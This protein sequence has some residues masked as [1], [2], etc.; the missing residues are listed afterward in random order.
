MRKKRGEKRGHTTDPRTSLGA[1]HSRV[2]RRRSCA[3]AAARII[4]STVPA[5]RPLHRCIMWLCA[6]SVVWRGSSRRAG[7]CKGATGG[8]TRRPRH[9]LASRCAPRAAWAD[10]GAQ[11]D[12]PASPHHHLVPAT[13]G[14]RA[15]GCRHSRRWP[16]R[17]WRRMWHRSQICH[18]RRRRLRATRPARLSTIRTSYPPP[19]PRRLRPSARQ[20]LSPA[21]ASSLSSA[22]SSS[23][24]LSTRPRLGIS[25]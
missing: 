10:P 15:P 5:I 23:T 13:R 21:R 18:T 16:R 2:L 19:Q 11:Q 22:T 25:Q 8:P 1:S 9:R 3:H 6:R 7:R 14:E 17:P 20:V 4:D 24:S 12:K